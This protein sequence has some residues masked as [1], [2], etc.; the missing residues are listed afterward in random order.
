MVDSEAI[1]VKS[2]EI[3][4][5]VVLMHLWGKPVSAELLQSAVKVLAGPDTPS[6]R[7]E[8]EQGVDYVA[9]WREGGL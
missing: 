3:A 4:L 5:R 7:P 6:K 9:R 2:E 8:G 1:K